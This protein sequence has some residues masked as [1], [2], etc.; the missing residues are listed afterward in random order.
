MET[1]LHKAEAAAQFTL[2]PSEYLWKSLQMH[3]KIAVIAPNPSR[4]FL[5]MQMFWEL[6]QCVL[7]IRENWQLPFRLP[8]VISMNLS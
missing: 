4:W 3:F 1:E 5:H 8:F 7:A 6:Y 2:Q